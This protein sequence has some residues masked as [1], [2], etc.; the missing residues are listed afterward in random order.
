VPAK[1]PVHAFRGRVASA[2]QAAGLTEAALPVAITI[3]A[4]FG[5]P[6]SHYRKVGVKPAAPPLPRPDCDNL[7]K[8]VLDGLQD[9]MGDDTRVARLA[10]QKAW[11]S[12]GSTT[13]TIATGF[14]GEG[15]TS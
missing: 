7:A 10:I 14:D 12:E 1:H 8:A 15:A 6:R 4:T 3:N 9:V 2:A 13:V 11:G 5:R